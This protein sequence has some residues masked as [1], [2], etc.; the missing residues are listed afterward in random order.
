MQDNLKGI[1]EGKINKNKNREKH[2]NGLDTNLKK[3]N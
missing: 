3:K 1:N 2:R